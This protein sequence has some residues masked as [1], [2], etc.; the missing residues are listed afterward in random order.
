MYLPGPVVSDK[1]RRGFTTPITTYTPTTTNTTVTTSPTSIT[2]DQA[3][4]SQP[5]TSFTTKDAAALANGDLTL[6]TSSATTSIDGLSATTNPAGDQATATINTAPNT[7]SWA[8]GVD[9]VTTGTANAASGTPVG[10][11]Q[12]H[13]NMPPFLA[14]NYIIAL[15]G[16][17]PPRN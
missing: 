3:Q 13:D 8:Q 15:Q 11:G 2:L 1:K 17:F 7:W 10:G 16:V 5:A 14:I 4:V 6:T 9:Q 12:P